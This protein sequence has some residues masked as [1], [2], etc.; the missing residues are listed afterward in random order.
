MQSYC[1]AAAIR[2]GWTEFWWS[3]EC[4]KKQSSLWSNFFMWLEISIRAHE[5]CNSLGFKLQHWWCHKKLAKY[6]H[7][8]MKNQLT[9]NACVEAVW[10]DN[11]QPNVELWRCSRVYIIQWRDLRSEFSEMSLKRRLATITT[12]RLKV[13]AYLSSHT[14]WN[15]YENSIKLSQ[16][17]TASILTE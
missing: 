9:N 13:N 12:W 2:K 17:N 15:K 7:P 11:I 1:Y 5:I 6:W 14:W 16:V 4:W 3:K 10:K 8:Y